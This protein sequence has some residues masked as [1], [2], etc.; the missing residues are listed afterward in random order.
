VLK[1]YKIS[2]IS[3]LSKRLGISTGLDSVTPQVAHA[4]LR[5][6]DLTVAALIAQLSCILH[7]TEYA[8]KWYH[9]HTINICDLFM[10]CGIQNCEDKIS[11]I[12]ICAC[13]PDRIRRICLGILPAIQ[14]YICLIDWEVR[15][16]YPRLVLL[17]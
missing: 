1:N 15:Q 8:G 2:A 4:W 9:V 7:P 6:K 12:C 5:Y 3:L 13:V 11:H 14:P 17:P 16:G 10:G